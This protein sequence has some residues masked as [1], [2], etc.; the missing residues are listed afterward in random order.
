MLVGIL[1]YLASLN[2][3]NIAAI[4]GLEEGGDRGLG[5]SLEWKVR[6]AYDVPPRQFDH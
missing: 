6:S 4:Y 3:Q 2:H 5:G 1:A